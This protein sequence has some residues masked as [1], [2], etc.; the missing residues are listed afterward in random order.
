MDYF[1][2]VSTL[3]AT[4]VACRGRDSATTPARRVVRRE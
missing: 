2:A 4:G 1:L 3:P